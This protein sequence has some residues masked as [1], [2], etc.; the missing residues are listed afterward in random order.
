MID[1]HCHILPNVDDG[2]ESLEESIAM[3]KIAE[4]EG[5]TK[6]VNTSHCHFDFKYKKGNELKLEL[7][8]FNQALKEENINI[9][10]LLGNELYY[11]SD[12]IERFDELDFFSMN[13][14]KYILMEFSPINFPKNIEDVIYEIKIRGYIPIIAH[15]ERYKQVQEDVNIVLDC[16][17]EGALIQVNASSILGKNGEKAEDTSKKLLDNNMVHFVATDAHSSNRRRPLIKDSYNYILKNYGK[18]VSEKLF[19]E[20][21]TAVIE[22]RDISILNP[23]KYE[24]KRSFLKRLFRK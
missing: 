7:E 4:S 12:L 5:I 22:N 9:E 17:K 15:A 18:E 16:I 1:I 24:E 20:N 10:V 8:K 14:S 23:T 21:P 13:N 19:I 3:A 11:T 2:S 6:I